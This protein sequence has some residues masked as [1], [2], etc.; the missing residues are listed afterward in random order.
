VRRA[1]T[2]VE[3]LLAI[4]LVSLLAVFIFKTFRMQSLSW[5]QVEKLDALSRLRVA[6]RRIRAELELGT[7]IL[8]PRWSGTGD[9]VARRLVYTGPTNDLRILYWTDDKKVKVRGLDGDPVTLCEEIENF[10]VRHPLKGQVVCEIT[11]E[12]ASLDEAEQKPVSVGIAAFAGN[13]FGGD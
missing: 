7:A 9:T 12:K 5:Y 11:A 2:I 13:G 8:H 3:L 4:V 6:E 1:M 10:E